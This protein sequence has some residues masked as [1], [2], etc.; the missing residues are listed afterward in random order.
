MNRLKCWIFGHQWHHPWSEH[1]HYCFRCWKTQSCNNP[2]FIEND[3]SKEQPQSLYRETANDGAYADDL[4]M[5]QKVR[6]SK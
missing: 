2:V 4:A 3:I 5:E 1:L 6:E